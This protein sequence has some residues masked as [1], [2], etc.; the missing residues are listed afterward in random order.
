MRRIEWNWMIYLIKFA[1]NHK[2][3]KR[4]LILGK[5]RKLGIKLWVQLSQPIAPQ[6]Q[7][8]PNFNCIGKIRKIR[9]TYLHRLK[10]N[11][12]YRR[13]NK[14]KKKNKK[15]IKSKCKQVKVKLK[16]KARFF[17]YKKKNR[18]IQLPETVS[19][20]LIENR[21]TVFGNYP[22][23]RRVDTLA[24]IPIGLHSPNLNR[25]PILECQERETKKKHKSN[26]KY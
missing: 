5:I 26:L 10:Q 13:Q 22:M 19:T 16:E 21:S 3:G 18:R 24:I 25:R 6:M 2:C 11:V 15:N 12:L 1:S 17:F 7:S 14:C 23:F 4:S 8:P 20:E 9:K